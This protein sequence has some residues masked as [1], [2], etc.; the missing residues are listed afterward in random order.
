MVCRRFFRTQ[1]NYSQKERTQT[2][3]SPSSAVPL[4]LYTVSPCTQPKA[5]YCSSLGLKTKI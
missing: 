2:E 3:K 1:A 4:S 5:E